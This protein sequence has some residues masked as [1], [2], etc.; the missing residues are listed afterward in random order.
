M[1]T[2][3]SEPEWDEEQLDLIAAEQIIR[4]NTGPN[5]EWLPE[6]TSDGADP[7]EYE[8]GFRYVA[9]GPFTNWAEKA[10][11]EAIELHRKELGED[12]DMDGKFWTVRKVEF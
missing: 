9:E 10:R 6:A 11:L 8:S 7:T 2:S 4:S 3:W 12:P 5:G 1:T